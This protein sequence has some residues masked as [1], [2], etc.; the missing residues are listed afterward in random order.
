MS[1]TNGQLLK[2]LTQ[3]QIDEFRVRGFVRIGPLLDDGL[4]A[5]LRAEYD[6]CFDEA[7][8]SNHFRNL[9]I[10]DTIDESQAEVVDLPAGGAMFHHCQTLHYTPPNKTDRQRRAFAIHFMPPGTRSGHDGQSL[11]VSFSRPLL[12]MHI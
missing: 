5:E 3:E 7:R 11:E 1:N 12:R 10:S 8:Q 6:R 4:I 9:A 2:S